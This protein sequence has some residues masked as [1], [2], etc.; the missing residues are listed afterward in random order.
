MMKRA[1]ALVLAVMMAASLF[2]CGKEELP[3]EGVVGDTL[4]SDMVEV[5]LTS[6]GFA[7]EGVSINEEDPDTFCTPIPFPYQ[8]TGNEM[9]DSLTL[10]LSQGTYVGVTETQCVVYLE[11]TVKI[12][13]EE[14][15]SQ[16]V[17]PTI[18]FNGTE[19]YSLNAISGKQLADYFNGEYDGVYYRQD[20]DGWDAM[21]LF[22]STGSEYLCRGVA[23]IP[24]EVETSTDAPLTV[25]FYL[26]SS[27]GTYE[28]YTFT[29]R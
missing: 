15:L 13:S 8:L 24:V 19:H 25:S 3:K 29:I 18:S 1:F 28:N 6:F 10:Q 11:F 14:T 21:P 27:D 7:E 5:T 9:M 22:W 2:G 23:R 16:S 4:K 26:P 12:T 20:G 17:M